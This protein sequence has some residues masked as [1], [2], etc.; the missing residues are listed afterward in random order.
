MT[1]NILDLDLIY[2]WLDLAFKEA[3]KYNNSNSSRKG[4]FRGPSTHLGSDDTYLRKLKDN[5]YQLET[6]TVE[7]L[8]SFASYGNK[9][10]HN[11]AITEKNCLNAIKNNMNSKIDV[12][13]KM[14]FLDCVTQYYL[15]LLDEDKENVTKLIEFIEHGRNSLICSNWKKTNTTN[16]KLIKNLRKVYLEMNTEI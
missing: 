16:Y 1:K 14:A 8:I 9:K 2:I 6:L 4:W 7:Q 10:F 12:E 3:V 11:D 15:L 13:F 5:L